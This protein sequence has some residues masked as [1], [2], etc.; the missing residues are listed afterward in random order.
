M[1]VPNHP[2]THLDPRSEVVEAYASHAKLHCVFNPHS[3]IDLEQGLALTAKYVRQHS[4]GFAPQGYTKI[5][6]RHNMP[7][8][9][10]QWLEKSSNL[11]KSHDGAPALALA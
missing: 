7:P 4:Q 9:W 6:V 8:S 10:V 3:P 5:E 1:G 2:I 11:T